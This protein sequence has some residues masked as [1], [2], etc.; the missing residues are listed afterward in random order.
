MI[1]QHA[2]VF[3]QQ[4][5]KAPP[6]FV[7]ALLFKRSTADEVAI[8]RLPCDGPGEGGRSD[9][10]A[11]GPRTSRAPVLTL[12]GEPCE[13][14]PIVCQQHRIEGRDAPSIQY[15]MMETE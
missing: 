4:P 11:A 9:L 1:A 3:E 14:L 12:P 13:A 7:L 2:L 5:D 15:R 10:I 8:R 6:A